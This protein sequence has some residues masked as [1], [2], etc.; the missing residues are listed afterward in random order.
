MQSK[1][2]PRLMDQV[3]RTLRTKHYSIRTEKTYCY[4]TRFFIRFHGIRHP[5]DMGTPEVRAFLE[6]LAVDRGVAAATQNQ[7]LN[8][9]VFL[10]SKVL[11]Q[12]LGDI[13]KVTRA[14]RP[15]RLP[16]VLTREEV[17]HVLE[18]LSGQAW[19]MA[20]LM[21]GGGLR[22]SEACRLRVRDIDFSREAITVRS[23]KGDKDRVTLLP[24]SLAAPL[25]ARIEATRRGLQGRPAA[26]RVPVTLPYALSRKYPNAG[27]SLGWQWLFPATRPC[28]DGNGRAVLHHIHTSAVQRAVKT[29]MWAAGLTRPGSCHTLRHSFATHLLAGGADI[30]TVQELMGHK[31]VETTQIYT[32]VLG[33]QF[34]GVRSPLG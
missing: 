12:P 23:G 29:A 31:S 13:G 15:Q 7:A 4:W 32:H 27:T 28:L 34:A 14:R 25:E 33:R 6:Y 9:I 19:L 8:A 5:A 1:R 26:A 21:Y 17:L 2:K 3:R 22:V 24:S 11:E 30:R 18:Q 20:S 16:V 10:Y